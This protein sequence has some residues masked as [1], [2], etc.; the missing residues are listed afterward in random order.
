MNL[1][2][3]QRSLVD[4][5]L[6]PLGDDDP[7]RELLEE[8]L[9][10]ATTLPSPPQGDP[11]EVASARMEATAKS[12]A[13]RRRLA[14][15]ALVV[16]VLII[17]WLTWLS[18]E[19]RSSFKL[20]FISVQFDDSF[21]S[22][23]LAKLILGDR[24][25]REAALIGQMVARL[26]PD[27]RLI[28]MGDLEAGDPVLRWKAVW[29]AYPDDPAHFMAYAAEVRFTTEE[30]PADLVETGERLDPG[31][32]WF[33]L[34]RAAPRIDDA[35]A[36]LVI[37][38]GRPTK[39]A[40]SVAPS[41]PTVKDQTVFTEIVSD[42]EQL[43]SMPRLDNHRSKL[44][45]TRLRGW[46]APVDYPDHVL[47]R[48]LCYQHPEGRM[49]PD[50]QVERLG[51]LFMAA[52]GQAAGS[53]DSESL[54]R[55]SKLFHRTFGKLAENPG[56]M[57][58]RKAARNAMVES[59][60]AFASAYTL[61]GDSSKASAFESLAD[62]LDPRKAK[63]YYSSWSDALGERR[64][65]QSAWMLNSGGLPGTSPVREEELRGGRLAEHAMTERFLFHGVTL[66]MALALLIVLLLNLRFRRSTGLLGTRLTG[67][68]TGFDRLVIALAGIAVPAMVY[69]A[70]VHAP[71]SRSRDFMIDDGQFEKM[72][73]QLSALSVSVMLCTLQTIRWRL[74]RRGAVLALGWNGFDPGW[75]LVPMALSAMPMAEYLP[76][77][78]EKWS[79]DD[80]WTIT[81]LWS[82]VGLPFA[83]VVVLAG[84]H[85]FGSAERRLHRAIVLKA[86]AP[87]MAMAMILAAMTISLLHR[88]E[89][90]WTRK[91]D[92]EAVTAE[93]IAFET[94]VK[95]ERADWLQAEQ[96]KFLRALE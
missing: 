45:S 46:P 14:Q 57:Y 62:G 20:L 66:L 33:R 90:E 82:L 55:F 3:E 31:N 27:E 4:A 18:P 95:R 54:D 67:L 58:H 7:R 8:S 83:W 89:K 40:T 24:K 64:G 80:D 63:R 72:L 51:D 94:R 15:V 65:S 53:G 75:W 22:S 81:A 70:V 1:T 93:R 69:A 88:V 13:L 71:W 35:V 96:L 38:R 29:D 48:V 6:R 39:G 12:F 28:A 79:V 42:L 2:P 32:G 59:G 21:V 9:V 10:L 60:R 17:P 84:G 34:L 43:A 19:S 73:V 74:G 78:F 41:G 26:P 47:T 92:F 5:V 61:L 86:M 50:R 23:D 36:P 44:N 76:E 91:I 37:S 56:L 77:M 52:A 49:L 30:W 11:V 87:F 68:L 85:L 25:E 16:A